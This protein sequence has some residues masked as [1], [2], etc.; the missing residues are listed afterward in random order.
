LDYSRNPTRTQ[1]QEKHEGGPC[2]SNPH[3]LSLIHEHNTMVA[4]RVVK[5]RRRRGSTSVAKH[6]PREPRR[7]QGSTLAAKHPPKAPERQLGP[8]ALSS[9]AS[10]L[11]GTNTTTAAKHPAKQQMTAKHRHALS[12]KASAIGGRPPRHQWQSIRMGKSDSGKASA[13]QQASMITPTNY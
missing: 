2:T 13:T 1:K 12:S 10:A 9:K 5:P 8:H 11:G 7:R 6:P 3:R 4:R